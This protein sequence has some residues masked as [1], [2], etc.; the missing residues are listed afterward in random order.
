MKVVPVS[1]GGSPCQCGRSWRRKKNW[2][3]KAVEEKQGVVWRVTGGKSLTESDTA[4]SLPGG[5]RSSQ[6]NLQ[7]DTGIFKI[8]SL[9]TTPHMTVYKLLLTPTTLWQ[10]TSDQEI[11]QKP[12]DSQRFERSFGSSPA[13][14]ARAESGAQASLSSPS[15]Q[16]LHARHAAPCSPPTLLPSSTL[17]FPGLMSREWLAS[18]DP[19]GGSETEDTLQQLQLCLPVCLPAGTDKGCFFFLEISSFYSF[20]GI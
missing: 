20:L 15:A 12:T 4:H 9:K 7:K 11:W 18:V 14:W 10:V 13:A 5:K 17:I 3:R 1:L 16:R 2:R 8:S 19:R 6:D